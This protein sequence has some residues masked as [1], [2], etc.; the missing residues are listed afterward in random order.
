MN[1]LE[2]EI[3]GM[4]SAAGD[5]SWVINGSCTRPLYDFSISERSD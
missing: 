5:S 3:V 4:I 2:Q 1:Q